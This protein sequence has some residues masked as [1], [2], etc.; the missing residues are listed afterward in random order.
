MSKSWVGAMYGGPCA[1]ATALPPHL[2]ALGLSR[3]HMFFR[4]PKLSFLPHT[5]NI[6]GKSL[7]RIFIYLGYSCDEFKK[8]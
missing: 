1:G 5:A 3:T 2:V 8:L 7:M 6:N 4:R